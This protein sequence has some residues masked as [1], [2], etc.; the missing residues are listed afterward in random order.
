MNEDEVGYCRPPKHAQFKKGAPSPNPNG[1]PK[2]TRSDLGDLVD[3]A[4]Y[5]AA[6]YS[7]NGKTKT[8][9][10]LRIS[11]MKHINNALNGDI[12]SAVALLEQRAHALKHGE[13]GGVIVIRV[14]GG[15]PK[16][17]Q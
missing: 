15:L 7:E 17:K 12:K 4:I 16:R 10:L 1:R 5:S 8:T 9:S 6:R 13:T 14:K 3:R 11:V 2:K